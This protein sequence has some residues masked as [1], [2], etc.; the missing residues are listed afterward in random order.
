[1]KRL[2]FGKEQESP[3]R[4]FSQG[5]ISFRIVIF[6]DNA[7]KGLCR[8][9]MF[10]VCDTNLASLKHSSSN[11]EHCSAYFPGY[12]FQKRRRNCLFFSPS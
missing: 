11:L 10:W 2:G 6:I 1:M 3:L 9:K 8:T 12:L 5:S 4:Q 7:G